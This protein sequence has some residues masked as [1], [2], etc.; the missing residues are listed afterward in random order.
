MNGKSVLF[1]TNRTYGVASCC[2]TSDSAGKKDDLIKELQN[3]G[4]RNWDPRRYPESL[5]LEVENGTMIRKN[6]QQIVTEIVE[7]SAGTNKVMQMN[8]GEGKSSVNVPILASALAKVF[9]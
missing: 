9:V 1:H 5:L 8:M 4:H 2:A 6:Q 3:P 7:Q